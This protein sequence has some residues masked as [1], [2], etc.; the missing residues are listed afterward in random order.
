VP[1]QLH[2]TDGDPILLT[3]DHFVFAPADRVDI[4]ACLGSMAEVQ[5]PEMGEPEPQFT[6]LRAGNAMHKSWEN[7]V[8]GR[9]VVMD[10]TLKLETNS[11]RRADALR[12]RVEAACGARL[13]YRAREHADPQSPR[14]QAA[15]GRAPAEPLESPEATALLRAYKERHYAGWLDQPLPALRGQTPRAAVRTK[16]GRERVDVLLKELENH[17]SLLEAGARFDFSRLRAALSL[18]G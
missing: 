3:V 1:P 5:P 9:A 2:N 14:V 8:I 12:L 17:E 7:T 4:E 10:G 15:H 18:E 11:V 6:F 16:A 13:R